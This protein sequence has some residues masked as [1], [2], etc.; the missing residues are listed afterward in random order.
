MYFAGISS[1]VQAL[2][3]PDLGIYSFPHFRYIEFFTAHGGVLLACLFMIFV[4]KAEPSHL[5]LWTTFLILN[6]YGAG[7]F[8]L[9]KLVHANYLYIMKKPDV[10]SLLDY[11]G[12]WPW[13]ILSLEGVMIIIFYLLYVPF[14]LKVKMNGKASD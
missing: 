4:E 9:D 12:T 2:L 8:L 11:L 3:T 10:A 13:Y 1:S 5:S 14:G 7:I 6:I